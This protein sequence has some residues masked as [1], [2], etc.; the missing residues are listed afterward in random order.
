MD[1]DLKRAQKRT[2]SL[3][4]PDFRAIF[5]AVPGL[6]MVLLPDEPNFTIVAVNAAFTHATLTKADDIVGRAV[7]EVFPDNPD[8]P[9]AD[10]VRNLRASLRRVLASKAPDTMAAQ[11]YDIRRPDSEGGAFEE[12][13][14]SPMNSPV[15]GPDGEVQFIIHRAEDITDFVRLKRVEA[16]QGRLAEAERIRAG[17]I[18]AELFLRSRELAQVKQLM[19]D[20]QLLSLLVENSPE[21]IGICDLQGVPVY[22]NR[23]ALALIGAHDWEEVRE[24][25]VPDY[26]VPEDRAFVREVVLPAARERGRWQGELR[27]QHWRTQ[28]T[29]PVYC[30]FF[31]VDDAAGRATH[32]ATITQDLRERKRTE[33]ELRE[34]EMRF[35]NAF[36]EAP[37]GM[38]LTTPNGVI[39][40][41][42]EAFRGMLGYNLEELQSN[43][44]SHFTHPDD[45]PRTRE[46]YAFLREHNRAPAALEKRYIRKDGQIVWVRAS[47]SMRRDAQ[48][49]AT[50][51]VAIIEDITERKRAETA[52]HQQW[53]TFDTALSNTPDFTYVFDLDGRFTYVNRALL[54]LWQK[55]LEEAVGKNFFELD[56]PP[57]LAARLQRQIQQV[58]DS[59]EPLRDDTPFTGPSGETRHYEYIF[60]PVVAADGRLQAVAGS[61]RDITERNK[62]EEALRKS[63]ERLTLALEAGGGVGTWD[64]DVPRDLVYT[65]PQF[66][67]LFSIAS[68]NAA[69]G[70]PAAHFVDRIHQDDRDGVRDRIQKALEAGGEFAEEYRV[71]QPDGS[72]RWVFA[73]GRCHLDAA[74]NPT[75]FPGVAVDITDRRRAETALRES[76]EQLRAIY[77]GTYE[78]I[79]LVSPDG[80]LLDCNRASLTFAGN[81]REDVI[82]R[83]YWDTPWFTTTPG[84]PDALRDAIARAAAGEFIRYETSLFRPS[85]ESRT[86]D[87]SLHPIR[88][89]RGEV[90]LLVPEGRDITDRKRAEDELKRSNEE[91]KRVNRELE[92]FAYVASHD[93]QEPLR[94]VN[95]YTQVILS[96]LGAEK[97]KLE[98]YAGFVRQGVNRMDAL[99]HDLLTFSRT[100]HANE[101]PAGTADLDAALSEALSVLKDRIRESGAAIAAD[102]LPA[103]RGDASQMAHVFQNLLSNALKYRKKHTPVEIQISAEQDGAAWTISVRDNGIGFDPQYAERI[104]GLFKRL[105]RDEYPGTGLGLAICKRIVER[106]GGRIWADGRPGQGAIFYFT[107]PAVNGSESN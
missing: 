76:Q 54:S 43:D 25:A 18:E 89:E 99:I 80:T 5:E 56:Y 60:V 68:E 86:F 82:G 61:T 14:W 106:Y 64:W 38:V 41:I 49:R 96:D 10:G 105:H 40:D 39:L 55:P 46:F 66:A 26:F 27:F 29:I 24:T 22:A 93:L 98:Q 58:I 81:R 102:M 65:N 16:E 1:P 9:Q 69:S 4:A 45:I 52:L 42:N 67:K 97:S 37:I 7:F 71:L 35:T 15:R 85:G 6:L 20:R 103:V 59:K 73:R 32:F 72:V 92:E 48:G 30:D 104:F 13:Y 8:D 3:P 23:S 51:L 62:T 107:L 50:Q 11:K 47:A 28:E 100:V 70:A 88:N 77:D 21:F 19:Q 79:G 83:P 78:Y 84:A 91:L 36:A 90:V 75:R 95:I 34:S 2:A 33:A 74:G 17:Q 63:E 31:R 53:H 94:M 101:L 44:S 57:A 87:F 12:R